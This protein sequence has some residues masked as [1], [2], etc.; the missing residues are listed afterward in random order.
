[1][2]DEAATAAK[3]TSAMMGQAAFS[4][5]LRVLNLAILTRLL[6]QSDMG[7]IAFLGI[8]Y[9]YMQFLGTLGLGHASPLIVPEEEANG[10]P[11]RVK[12]FL[13]R[14]VGFIVVSTIGMVALVIVLSPFLTIGSGISPDLIC[15]IAIVAPFSAL[16]AFLDSFLLARYRIKKLLFGRVA[17]DVTRIAGT[18]GLVLVGTGVFGVVAGW[19]L[20]EMVAVLVFGVAAIRG[21]QI[22]SVSIPM[23]PILAFALP[24]LIFQAID[25]TIQNTDRLILLHITDLASL[26]VYDVFLRV[27]Y[28]LSLVSLTIASAIYPLLT[29]FRLKLENQENSEIGMGDAITHLVRYILM[30]LVPLA[31]IAALNPYVVLDIL[32]GTQYATYPDATLAFSLLI[33]AYALWGVIYGV[34]T[35]LR[36]MG[37]AKFFVVAGLGI[38]VFEFIGC[39]YLTEALGLLGAA[40]ARALYVLVLFL[41]SWGRL[42]QKGV[43]GL[44]SIL[45]S[46]LRIGVASILGGAL[47]FLL[48]P[49]NLIEL[50]VYVGLAAGLYFLLLFLLREVRALDFTIVRSVL[51]ERT[52]WLVEKIETRYLPRSE[53]PS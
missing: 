50:V 32:F 17:F 3:G 12:G 10:N 21:L 51:P 22:S 20:A 5:F 8:F 14:S 28:M 33:M 9:G 36:A 52:H 42:I 38:I 46:L 15:F 43:A 45:S 24:N 37:E 30:L 23:K 7:V 49:S 16:E 31:V 4:G 19:M 6:L 18:V 40:I 11:G 39:W 34:H 26:G 44:S 48:A 25:V 27:L 29:R 53:K 13:R 41:V 47:V 2:S 1:M 35:S